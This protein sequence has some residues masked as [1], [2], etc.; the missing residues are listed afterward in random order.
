MTIR[1]GLDPDL[2]KRYAEL[3]TNR[4]VAL[5][6]GDDEIDWD[7]V[8]SCDL[9]VRVNDHYIRQ[10]HRVDIL[11]HSCASDLLYELDPLMDT[12]FFWLQGMMRLFSKVESNTMESFCA[13]RGI[14]CGTFLNA[15]AP[16]YALMPEL[17][18]LPPEYQWLKDFNET[19][20]YPFTGVVALKH[21]EMHSCRSIYVDGMTFY[22]QNGAIPVR[23]QRHHTSK[24]LEY[25]LQLEHG[26]K[27]CFSAK[28][29]SL[30]VSHKEKKWK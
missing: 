30:L 27:V 3:L 29:R 26:G 2:L 18:P 13:E 15:T 24:Q 25:L 23:H 6:G 16:L 11:Y 9:V 7:K 14:P 1:V 20:S 17:N 8:E 28:L 5:V 4:T 10:G 19:Y 12:K 22:A 21:L